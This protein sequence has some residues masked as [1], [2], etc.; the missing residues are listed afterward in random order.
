MG[1]DAFQDMAAWYLKSPFVQILGAALLALGAFTLFQPGTHSTVICPASQ[2]RQLILALQ[3]LGVLMDACI[4]VLA[5]RAMQWARTSRQRFLKLG[6]VL[7]SAAF[8]VTVGIFVPTL[9]LY[10]ASPGSPFAEISHVGSLYCFHVLGQSL[11]LLTVSSILFALQYPPLASSGI[12]TFVCGVCAAW[13][14]L[15]LLGTYEQ[16]SKAQVMWGTLVLSIGFVVFAFRNHVRHILFSRS[17]ITFAL[18]AWVIGTISYTA[19]TPVVLDRHP[20]NRN[21]YNARQAA[22]RWKVQDARVSERLPIAVKEYMERHG[23]RKPPPKFDVWWQYAMDR[24]SLVIDHFPQIDADINPFFGI[25]P[26]KIREEV[27]KLGAHLGII[28]LSIKQGVVTPQPSKEPLDNATLAIINDLVDLLQPFAGHLADM[29]LP[30]NLLEVPRVLVPKSDGA[31]LQNTDSPSVDDAV[32]PWEYRHLMGQACPDNSLA[33]AEFHS[34]NGE[35]CAPCANP[36]SLGQF[37]GDVD[38][39]RDMCHQPDMLDLHGFFMSQQ[40]LRPFSDLVPVFSR[41][42][43]DQFQDIL[44]PLSR[45][46]HE[47][48]AEADKIFLEKENRLFWRGE[49]SE[50][51][52]ARPRLLVGGHQER[53][54]HLANNASAG[55]YVT[56]LLAKDGDT[57][58]FVYEKV[59]LGEANHALKMDIGISEYATCTSTECEEAKMEFGTKPKDKEGAE[60]RNSRYVMV[61]DDD[62]GPPSDVMKVVRSN[63]IPFVATIFKVCGH[64]LLVVLRS[65]ADEPIQR[66]GILID[67]SRGCIMSPSTF[68]STVSTAHWPISWAWRARGPS[69]GAT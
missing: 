40:P 44:I 26:K 59:P 19:W 41:A 1:N 9:S 8:C 30:I 3:I 56:M 36:Q 46:S 35:I 14:K 23:G 27:D 32:S 12:I 28:M 10:S 20:V 58:K 6:S 54:T 52:T 47:Y 42:K 7:G 55:D 15:P 64:E 34:H 4:L 21:V 2:S 31:R 67:F 48:R 5:W 29:D 11:V 50:E 25:K 45:N 60:Q 65:D 33:R 66:N 68:G 37:L 22:D 17:L 62:D 24:D 38:K 16:L 57:D 18:L 63:G 53:L 39:S 13:Q 49:L 69:M 51:A 43:G 61:M